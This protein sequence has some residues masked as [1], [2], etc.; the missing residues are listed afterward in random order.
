VSSSFRPSSRVRRFAVFA[1][2]VTAITMIAMVATGPTAEASPPSPAVLSP[3]DLLVATSVFQNDPN[4]VAGTTQ[5]P[6]GCGGTTFDPCGTAVA[7]GDYPYVFNNDASDGSFG[8]AS[9]ITLEELTTA[10]AL[11]KSIQVPNSTQAGVTSSSD[12]MVT[13][14]SSKSELAVNLSTDGKYVT[15][16]GYNAPVDAVDVSNG[17]TPGDVDPTVADPVTTYREVA[18]LGANGQFQFT[19]TNA[20]SGDNGRAAILNDEPGAGLYYA[21]GNAGNGANPE[22]A[23]VITGAGAQLI[24]PSGQPTAA[25]NPPQP[26]AVGSF[27]IEQLGDKADKSGKDDNYRGLTVY[28][29]VLY[30]TKGSGGN[31]VDTIYFV[32][33]T[34]KAC[35]S[36]FGLP[37]P[38]ASLP[39]TS[40]FT[41]SINDAALGLTAK[42]PGLAPE[43]MCILKGF[44]TVLAKGATDASDYPFGVWFANPYTAYVADE[45]AGDNTYDPST[46]TYTAAAASTTAGLQKWVFDAATQQWNLAY[47]L[48]NGLNLGV[49]YTVPGYPTGDNTGPGGT[50]LPWAPATGGLRNLTGQVNPNGTVSIW[51][52]TST[53]SGSGDQGAD[54]NEL[55]EV[56][57]N[58]GAT[59][60]P[61]GESFQTVIAPA[62][63]TVIRG[64]AF[65][66]G[67]TAP[68]GNVTCA[69]NTYSDATITGNLSV[70]SG[71]TCTLADVTVEGNVQVRAGGSLLDAA[72]TIDGNLQVT[73]AAWIDVRGGLING[74]VQ[75]QQTTGTP[76]V[77]DAGT[78][79]DLCGATVRGNV[80]VSGNGAGAPF[81]IGAVPDCA[82]PL[83]IA[84][85]L[86]VD[87]NAGP[88]A[89]GPGGNGQGNTAQGNIQVSGNT[90]GGSLQDNQAGGNC[91]LGPDTPGLI[92]AGNTAAGHN[93]CN[94]TA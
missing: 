84:G 24:Q 76:D 66:P 67:T 30:Y 7:S 39:T 27:N 46:N 75:V 41:Y 62:N 92:G 82:A 29:N 63:A 51:A 47:T 11:V 93:T 8:V 2:A 36:G 59:A 6:P 40:N 33:P 15:F 22:P 94:A 34:G 68:A 25:Q 35:P 55:V 43:N 87:N 60:Q 14:F 57:D 45:G 72:S 53:V 50:G 37:E 78:A 74:N 52:E 58:L 61:V 80:Q 81:D 85:N 16:M 48:Q 73:Q 13:S 12:Q 79:N 88:V 38:G 83:T 21:A 90:G 31:G 77:G 54:P 69:G 56:T 71:S 4:I 20:F 44:P 17:S 91:L 23:Q 89:I 49:P 70:P 86:Q 26:T 32:D 18:Q 64:V 5:L 9:P 42:N 10:G 3:G 1:P 19:E 28:D 65:T